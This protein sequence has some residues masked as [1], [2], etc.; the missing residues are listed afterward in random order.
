[1]GEFGSPVAPRTRV[2]VPG[3]RWLRVEQTESADVARREHLHISQLVWRQ[4]GWDPRAIPRQAAATVRLL[5]G[6]HHRYLR[7]DVSDFWSGSV[8]LHDRASCCCDVNRLLDAGDQFL[9]GCL[10]TRHLQDL[11]MEDGS[12]GDAFASYH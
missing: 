4:F 9:F 3:R 11:A 7:H 10:L 12:H 6:P 8:R 2:Y 1:M 5:C